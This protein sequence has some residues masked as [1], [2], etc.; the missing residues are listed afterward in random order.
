M[1]GETAVGTKAKDIKLDIFKSLFQGFS[2]LNRKERLQRL[3]Q[4]GALSAEDLKFLN[5]GA[6][7]DPGL[8]E[9][10]IENVIGYFKLPMG[11]AANFVIDGKP[12]VIP[13]AVEETSIIAAASKTAKWVRDYG[14]ITTEVVGKNIIGQIQVKRVKDFESFKQKILESKEVLIDAANRSV[15]QGLVRRGGGVRDIQVRSVDRGDSHVMA[16]IHVLADTCDAMGANIVNTMAETVA[17]FLPDLFPCEVGLKI[18]TNLTDERRAW[19]RCH[20][21]RSAFHNRYFTGREVVER[22]V[23]AYRFA[24]HDIYRATTHNKGVMNG[25]DSVLI[26]TGNDWR[27]V[28]AG[29]HAYAARSGVYRPMTE[30][31]MDKNGDLC[32]YLELPMAVGTVGGVTKLHPTAQAALKLLGNPTAQGLAEIV[33]AVGLAQNLSALR[34]LASEGIQ[35]GHMDLHRSNLELLERLGAVRH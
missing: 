29:A 16:V 13:M 27:A 22:I 26:A 35:R 7:V 32:G 20:V 19:A 34:A 1:K 23:R 14:S 8:A 33:C 31:H 28:E 18:L 24:Y 10:F 17:A 30:W 2:K 15:A 4:M 6:P 3:Y 21:P 5:A 11:V 25:I 9:N 12:Y